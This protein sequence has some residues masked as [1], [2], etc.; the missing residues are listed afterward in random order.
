MQGTGNTTCNYCGTH[1]SPTDSL[2]GSPRMPHRE[3]ETV[4]SLSQRGAPRGVTDTTQE[5]FRFYIRSFAAI[6]I[7]KRCCLHGGFC[8][9]L[10]AGRGF[11]LGRLTGSEERVVTA[12]NGS[13]L[14]V[15]QQCVGTA[16]CR[17]QRT[18]EKPMGRGLHAGCGYGIALHSLLSSSQPGLRW[19]ALQNR[20]LGAIL[21]YS[22]LMF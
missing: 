7:R 11:V 16:L 3:F 17:R 1:G 15:L 2:K 9:K 5:F 19:W 4:R 20:W 8:G 6:A 14:M 13:T 10:L 21:H 12:G 22:P 18:F